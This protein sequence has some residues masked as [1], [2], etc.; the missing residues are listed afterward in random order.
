[1]KMNEC[2]PKITKEPKEPES[3]TDIKTLFEYSRQI[4]SI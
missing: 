2:E 3:V 4:K 1:M